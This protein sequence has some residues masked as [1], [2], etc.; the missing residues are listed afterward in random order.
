VDDPGAP[1]I[2][3]SGR[4]AVLGAAGALCLFAVL[5]SCLS[6]QPRPP[7]RPPPA[8]FAVLA[9]DI[10][11]FRALPLKRDV[12]L[13]AAAENL[14]R[15]ELTAPFELTH[16]ERAYK[17][18]ALVGEDADLG[19]AL[20]EFRQLDRLFTYDAVR[21]S[22]ALEP[23]ADKLGLPFEAT[24][25]TLAREA[26]FGF[27]VVAALQEQNFH[28]QEKIRLA[29]LEDHR[30]ALR[31]LAIGDAAVTLIARTN[32]RIDFTAADVA[33][34]GQ[35]AGALEKAAAGLPGFVRDKITFPYR[36]GS[37]FVLWAL[38]ARGWSGVD[39]LYVN[40]PLSSAAV[41]HPEK[42]FLLGERPLRFF[43]AALRSVAKDGFIVEQ[44]LGAHLL[45]GLLAGALDANLAGAVAAAWRG[46]QLFAFQDGGEFV[47]AWYSSWATA[48]QAAAFQRAYK[49]VLERRQ[50]I[51]FDTPVKPSANSSLSGRTRANRGVWL[52]TQGPAVLFLSGVPLERLRQRVE[53][54]WRDLEIEADPAVIRFDSVRNRRQ[55]SLSSR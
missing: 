8:G 3:L 15:D 49:N 14:T 28:W 9:H 29:F 23:A 46:D 50:R 18:I 24:D 47:T 6:S 31:A 41:L 54:A 37:R 27:A 48:Q 40:P 52:E 22:I 17:A 38:K 33:R 32:N 26:P 5:A 34:T 13:A 36:D 4:R 55:L 1:S 16:V 42:Y 2:K 25:P 30:L 43:P 19:A 45:R 10:A 35:F 7:L 11:K 39:A 12:A 21:G 53:D 51:R 44:S 20:G